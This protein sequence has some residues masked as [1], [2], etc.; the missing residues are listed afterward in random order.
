MNTSDPESDLT[1]LLTSGPRL[2][3]KV[4][5][6]TDR[7]TAGALWA[8]MTHSPGTGR[9]IY[10]SMHVARQRICMYA[11]KCQICGNPASRD[12]DGW[13][14]I[15]WRRPW[16]PPTWPE[17][18]LTEQ[19]PLCEP[20]ARMAVEQCPHLGRGDY[21]VLRVRT[22]RLWGI[23]GTNYQLTTSGWRARESNV[24]VP[25]GHVG[26]NAVLASRMIRE[27]RNVTVIDLPK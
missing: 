8:R 14:F 18:S 17:G 16:D 13:L 1:V 6:E 25:Y 2:G 27:L 22:P 4:P 5:R 7:D 19:P 15:N 26:L 12:E 24:M 3:Y 21:A 9:P 11:M 23:S 10:D 20:H